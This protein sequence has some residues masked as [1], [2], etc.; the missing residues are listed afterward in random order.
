MALTLRQTTKE[1]YDKYEWEK[2]WY[3][4]FYERC[5]KN[6][7]ARK[8]DKKQLE[9]FP[10]LI[11]VD[12]SKRARKGNGVFQKEYEYYNNYTG[13]K[14]TR[15]QYR[16]R[17]VCGYKKEDA[18]LTWK[19]WYVTRQWRHRERSFNIQSEK[20]IRDNDRL[21]KF[22]E[23]VNKPELS[24][25]EKCIEITYPKNVAMVFKKEYENAIEQ[26]EYTIQIDPLDNESRNKLKNIE[27]EYKVF[28]AWNE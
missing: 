4:M 15:Q 3:Q 26:L 9:L 14:C 13:D 28:C 25:T 20:K 21:L 7:L 6:W 5:V 10:L 23:K 12:Y 17:L 16:A 18:V 22:M 24:A 27:M 8:T 2:V 11:L 1:Y 19:A